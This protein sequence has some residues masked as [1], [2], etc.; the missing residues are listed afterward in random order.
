M[1]ETILQQDDDD[2]DDDRFQICSSGREGKVHVWVFLKGLSAC[3][4]LR[5]ECYEAV[6]DEKDTE[7]K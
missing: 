2:D 5:M 7:K 6:L 4:W 3:M 1:K